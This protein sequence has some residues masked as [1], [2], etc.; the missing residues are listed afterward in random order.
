MDPMTDRI[1][2]DWTGDITARW[3]RDVVQIGH[4]LHASP[5]FTDEAL[6]RL[7]EVY[8]R[9]HYD[10]HT[11]AVARE[12]HAAESWREGDL[13]RSTGEEVLDAIKG[14]HIWLNLRKVMLVSA[15]H[16]ELLGRI[17]AEVESHVPGLSTFK[18]NLG[19]LMSS[20]TA[21]VFY[22]AD[23]PGQSLWQIRGRKRVF[24]Y[25]T[26]APFISPQEIERIILGEADEQDMTYQPWFDERATVVDLE[27]GQMLH[28][29]LNG[30]HRVQNLDCFNISVTT[31]HWS[32]EIRASYA[33]HYANGILRRHGFSPAHGL[34]GPAAWAKMGLAALYK[35]SGAQKQRKYERFIDF[36]VDP[37]APGGFADVP[38][39]LRTE[40]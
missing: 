33:V 26:E 8:P 19:I 28:W 31:E 35:Y 10:L 3:G 7:I 29:P 20:P 24:V 1:F 30:P 27:P 4:R 18:H 38:R 25:P 21:Q 11:M 34:T 16:G 32:P 12:G 39:R 22:H 15:P 40:F 6:A 23:I 36:V 2:V 9:E 14:G 13:G 5:L 37:K 17:F